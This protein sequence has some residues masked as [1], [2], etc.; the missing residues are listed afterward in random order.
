ME[1]RVRYESEV[2]SESVGE[3]E[4]RRRD[5]SA[6][7]GCE[8]QEWSSSAGRHRV[9]AA[10]E[11]KTQVLIC[12]PRGGLAEAGPARSFSIFPSRP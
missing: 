9:R 12:S 7:R 5:Q 11:G 1:L 3:T 6:G 10:L 4:R 2:Y 8:E